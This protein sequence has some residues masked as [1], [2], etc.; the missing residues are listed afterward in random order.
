MRKV[1]VQTQYDAMLICLDKTARPFAQMFERCKWFAGMFTDFKLC[2][3]SPDA[4]REAVR[5][6][7]TS[8]FIE[9][10]EAME[11]LDWKNHHSKSDADDIEGLKEELIDIQHFLLDA[12]LALGMTPGEFMQEFIQK[13]EVNWSRQLEGRDHDD[14]YELT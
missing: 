8:I 3:I 11:K 5:Y 7:L 1:D 4:R 2:K 13:N 10:A 14:D 12:A 6:Y 9:T